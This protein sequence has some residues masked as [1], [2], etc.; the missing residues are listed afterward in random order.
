M[1]SIAF[2]SLEYQHRQVMQELDAAFSKVI[3]KGNFILGKCV[4]SFEKEYAKFQGVKHC[5]GTGNGHDALLIALKALGIGNGDEVIVPSHTCQAT[6]LAVI[7]TGARPIPVE[8]DE[9]MTIDP[10]KIESAISFKTKAIIPV[11]LYGQPCEMDA[12][13]SIAKKSNLFVIEDNAQA[14]G[15]KFKNQ[16][17]GSFGHINATSF[18]PTKNLGAIGDG[19]AITTNED[20]LYE[21]AKAIGNYGSVK[22]D[23]HFIQGMNSRLDELQAAF[24]SIKL[25]KLEKWNELRKQNANIYF[26]NLQPVG[27]ILLPPKATEDSKPVYHQFVIRTTHRDKLKAY[28]DKNEIGTAIHYPVPVHLQKAYSDLGFSKG[29]FPIAQRLAET[30]LSLPVWPGLKK[31]EIEFVCDEIK[32]FYSKAQSYTTI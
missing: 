4:D 23:E 12:I 7:N 13:M 24:L 5:A 20:H 15:A 31:E 29:S 32:E 27:D 1:Q 25:K 9:S 10:A 26:Q 6:W 18:Y 19:G 16:I 8:V 22:K 21:L 28:L 17:T 30:V 3:T 11:H 14:H 2:F